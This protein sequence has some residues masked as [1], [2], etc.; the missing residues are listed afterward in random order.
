MAACAV[1]SAVAAVLQLLQEFVTAGQHCC[2]YQVYSKQSDKLTE[3]LC[4][5][6]ALCDCAK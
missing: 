2:G 6:L 5:Y 3:A 1:M 4:N